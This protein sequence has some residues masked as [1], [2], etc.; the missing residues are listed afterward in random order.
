MGSLLLQKMVSHA[1]ATGNAPGSFIVLIA[2]DLFLVPASNLSLNILLQDFPTGDD[3]FLLFMNSTHG[4]MYA[5][6]SRFSVVSQVSGPSGAKP[7]SGV[8]TVT[9]SGAPN[10]TRLF[11]TTFAA[12]GNGGLTSWG[13]VGQ[14]WLFGTVLA[15]CLAG[16]AWIFR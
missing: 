3:Y 2:P 6:S 15:G 9:V 13:D 11:A 5:T 16:A 10:P 14:A 7:I 1:T 12:L 4:A 8:E